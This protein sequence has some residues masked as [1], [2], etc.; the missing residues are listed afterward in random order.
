MNLSKKIDTYWKTL[1]SKYPA[2]VY[3]GKIKTIQFEQLKNAIDNKKEKFLK[4]LIKNI[5]V[6]RSLHC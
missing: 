1:E 2:P 6:K 3:V 5:Y 4:N